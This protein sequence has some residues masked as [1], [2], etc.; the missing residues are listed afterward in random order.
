VI[1]IDTNVLSALMR[2]VP[3]RPVVEW[4]DRQ[5]P[6]SIWITS[7]TLFEARIGL[8]LLPKGKH[9]QTL[10]AAFDKL[11]IED[12][13]GRV[14]DFD[15]P[16]AEAA[17]Q[18]AAGRQREGQSIDMRDTQIAGIVIARR[19]ELATRNVRHFSDLNVTVINPWAGSA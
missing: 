16:A 7:I 13:E 2:K 3:E 1:V 17:A 10:E 11:M 19:A 18:L 4:L 15:Q 8:A 5:A 9:R 12:L 6:E 14:L